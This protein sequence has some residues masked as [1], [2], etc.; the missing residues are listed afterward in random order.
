MSIKLFILAVFSAAL[1]FSQ[2]S[3]I[4]KDPRWQTIGAGPLSS[5]PS[6][7]TANRSV[8][9]CNGAGCSNGFEVD[10]CV[11]TSAGV[12]TWAAPAGGATGPAG[13][14][15]PA[16]PTGST[17]LLSGTLASIPATCT[18]GASLY[19][20]TDQPTG[21]QIYGCT[22]TN[23]WT[24]IPYSQGASN[25]G[26]CSVGQ[27]F[28][29]TAAT[30]GSNL[31]LCTSANTYTQVA[32]SSSGITALTGDVSASGPGSATATLATVNSGPGTCGDATHVCQQTVNGKGLTTSTTQIAI[33][34][35]SGL[36]ATIISACAQTG[37]DWGTKV[38]AA[39]TAL[40][41]GVGE[42]WLDGGCAGTN[43]TAV[44]IP[45]GDVLH[46]Y[47]GTYTSS[48]QITIL[49]SLLMEG[50]SG[51]YQTPTP[52][53]AQTTLFEA[54]SANLN[55]FINFAG[56]GTTPTPSMLSGGQINCNSTNNSSAGVCL[57]ITNAY[58]METTVP[59][60]VSN[61]K[62]DCV[63][64]T[65]SYIGGLPL[66]S[67]PK[68]RVKAE[69]AGAAALHI[70]NVPDLEVLPGSELQHAVNAI[71]CLD[72]GGLVVTGT[73]ISNTSGPAILVSGTSTLTMSL[74]I[75]I[76]GNRFGTNMQGAIVVTGA[77]VDNSALGCVANL[78]FA[79]NLSSYSSPTNNTYDYIQVNDSSGN[80][81]VDNFILSTSGNTWRY[82][83]H[84]I[85][86]GHSLSGYDLL[87][88]NN[89]NGTF[90]TGTV[91]LYST[92]SQCS[93]LNV[94]GTTLAGCLKVTNTGTGAATYTQST[95]TINIPISSLIACTNVSV[96]TGV[97]T[98]PS[99]AGCNSIAIVQPTT[100]ITSIAATNGWT[101]SA[102]TGVI[103][104]QI[105][106]FSYQAP[107]SSGS[108]T[109]VCPTVIGTANCPILPV[110]ASALVYFLLQWNGTSFQPVVGNTSGHGIYSQTAPPG[111]TALTAY[112]SGTSLPYYDSS[113]NG[114]MA[115]AAL[116]GG[117]PNI[118]HGWLK[119]ANSVA[120]QCNPDTGVC[121]GV[122]GMVVTA[123]TGT[124][125]LANG[126]TFTINNTLTFAGTDSTTTTFPT[127]SQTLMGLNQVNLGGTAFTI[128]MHSVTA[129]D[130]FR[131]TNQAS[132]TTSLKG[133]I[134]YD[135]TSNNYHLNNGSDLIAG[136][137]SGAFTNGDCL[138]AGVSSGSLSIV[139]T[140]ST[141]GTGGGSPTF[142]IN[143]SISTTY[144]TTA[145]DFSNCRTIPVTSGTFTV[146]LVATGSQPTNGQCV[147]IINYGT[148]VVTIS[149]N[150]QNING[151]TAS[152]SLPAGSATAPTGAFVVSDAINYEGQIFG[153]SSSSTPG[154]AAIVN[155]TPVTV[156]SA[157]TTPQIL[158][159]LAIPAGGLNSANL[160]SLLHNSG[161]FT[162]ALAQTPTL[163]FSATLCTSTGGGGTCITL[164]SITTGSTVAATNNIWNF[165]LKAGTTAIG[166]SG[167]LMVHGFAA[168]DIGATSTI[169]DSVYNDVNTA[170]TSNIN[171]AA[172]LYL[173]F[174]V[175]TSSGNAGNSFTSQIAAEM[176]QTL[177]SAL[178]T[179]VNNA[180]GS[181][182]VTADPGTTG[183]VVES[184][185]GSPGTIIT[186][187]LAAGNGISITNVSG[188]A[189]NPSISNPNFAT[190]DTTYSGDFLCNTTTTVAP[191]A[192]TTNISTTETYFTNP[193]YTFGGGSTSSTLDGTHTG[194]GF[195]TMFDMAAAAGFLQLKL[196][197][198]SA[199][200]AGSPGTCTGRVTLWESNNATAGTY[201]IHGDTAVCRLVQ[202]GATTVSTSCNLRTVA[203][204]TGSAYSATQAS[205]PNGS[206]NWVAVWS[207]VYNA[208]GP[209]QNV[210][211]QIANVNKSFH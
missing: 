80:N 124:F 118:W 158:Q 182:F 128:D 164:A 47:P 60:L 23:A 188:V 189:G 82:G 57:Y 52:N 11:S 160:I 16:G 155:L 140:G 102:P 180:V 75:Q 39:V 202:T 10:Y 107:A 25:P 142:P 157:V 59:T 84:E 152:L 27:I 139:D 69:N 145:A 37:S 116:V 135:T 4:P 187:S 203:G 132:F 95:N 36:P 38:N 5:R 26:T 46:L 49:G 123:S 184:A 175:T 42:I 48:A 76:L 103:T 8:Y 159:E 13:P 101:G 65:S 201:T 137:M 133:S 94:V 125:T 146:T 109:M 194:F 210:V 149:R 85:D 112:G 17:G 172:A 93:D 179:A 130:P 77:C 173:D 150:G 71:N 168:V 205:V 1:L 51:G 167:N 68:L 90:G 131:V 166:A 114:N 113:N 64:V 44:S 40:G 6:L 170:V 105:Y 74:N 63:Y 19:Q 183:F 186:R 20:A 196:N 96:T 32:G 72:C 106:Y 185:T 207:I 7:G 12:C 178:V 55:P 2:S 193:V 33:T 78:M 3:T 122:N 97:A 161:I 199:F 198:C 92:T 163:T 29:N 56:N 54:N 66:N 22:T 169:A 197:A 119:T 100:T 154:S 117:N 144:T 206:A 195:E 86:N 21:L 89:Y 15:G 190:A 200:T 91:L 34:G 88:N 50:N 143:A 110:E 45:I 136:L 67:S 98:Y 192:C 171:L 31:Y 61:C 14:V 148:G 43:A 87:A 147:W 176:P 73:D 18:V 79:N 99:L 111:S 181:V 62:T 138:K 58:R 126:K 108:A 28:F 151:G 41:A 121:T 104:N 9:I 30:A 174:R 134:G 115:V 191:Y 162:I 129:A 83:I 177:G 53:Q 127:T 120:G 204:S 24:R 165:D 153:A 156:S 209:Q 35:A 81:F 70:V 141:C 211:N 208:A